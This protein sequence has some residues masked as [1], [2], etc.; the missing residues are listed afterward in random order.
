MQ[1][2]QSCIRRDEL[3]SGLAGPLHRHLINLPSRDTRQ[4]QERLLYSKS[5]SSRRYWST[6]AAANWASA[7]ASTKHEGGRHSGATSQKLIKQR[8]HQTEAHW[9][10]RWTDRRSSLVIAWKNHHFTASLPQYC[11]GGERVGTCVHRE[12]EPWLKPTLMCWNISGFL[13]NIKST[14]RRN[15]QKLD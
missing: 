14:K 6:I 12:N 2:G 13:K 8:K 3:H 4:Q 15:L 10:Q 7:V 11:G 5:L 9:A 1:L